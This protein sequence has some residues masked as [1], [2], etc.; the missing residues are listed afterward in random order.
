MNSIETVA[1]VLTV[2]FMVFATRRA[3]L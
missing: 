2:Y 1:A 3:T